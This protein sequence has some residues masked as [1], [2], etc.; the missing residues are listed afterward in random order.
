VL[1]GIRYKPQISQIDADFC[2]LVANWVV[3]R[4]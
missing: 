1:F 3:A 4:I 2:W